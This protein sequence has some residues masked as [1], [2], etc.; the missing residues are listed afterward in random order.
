VKEAG[1]RNLALRQ[2]PARIEAPITDAT[3][4]I[5]VIEVFGVDPDAVEVVEVVV[6]SGD[7]NRS[8]SRG[9]EARRR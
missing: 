9:Y 5:R 7:F 4:P 8:R 3:A 6:D 2:N 1:Q